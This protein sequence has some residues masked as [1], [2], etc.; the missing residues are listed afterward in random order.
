M[1]LLVTAALA[2]AA[3][4]HGFSCSS[5]TTTFPSGTADSTKRAEMRACLSQHVDDIT[6][7]TQYC[8]AVMHQI[9]TGEHKLTCYELPS[10]SCPIDK[11][12]AAGQAGISVSN[13]NNILHA[14]CGVRPTLTPA[15]APMDGCRMGPYPFG[16]NEW[17]IDN[18]YPD[19]EDFVEDCL[20]HCATVG[21][22]DPNSPTLHHIGLLSL[23]RPATGD[24][25][26]S[27]VCSKAAD[28]AA[29]TSSTCTTNPYSCPLPDGHT[30]DPKCVYNS[31]GIA[32]YHYVFYNN[33]MNVPSVPEF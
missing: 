10:S 11:N 20:T 32:Q 33:H 25:R 26:V 19:G 2:A 30:Y 4:V 5:F 15:Y 18:A 22:T 6:G 14:A 9:P 16:Q 28:T 12:A 29:D 3:G 13:N 23:F 8:G 21:V 31:A 27:C 1:K 24:T 17:I 7:N